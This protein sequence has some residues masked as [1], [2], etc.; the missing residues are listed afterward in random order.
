[1]YVARGRDHRSG[2]A[3][4]VEGSTAVGTRVVPALS[5]IALTASLAACGDTATT[6]DS[7]ERSTSS[8]TPPGTVGDA[9]AAS[10]EVLAAAVLHRVD[11]Y[12]GGFYTTLFIID[13]VG[14]YTADAGYIT[15]WVDGR[16]LSALE[17]TAIETALGPRAVT[18]ISHWRDVRGEPPSDVLPARQAIILLAEP[19]IDESRAEV[20]T[21]LSCGSTCSYGATSMLERSSGGE[22]LVTGET[23]VFVS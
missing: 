8:A 11:T 18:W 2:C 3:G 19:S 17:R 4:I 5:L 12:A 1:M 15:D 22:W 10:P 9:D 13:R 6:G 21:E 16:P 7:A 20:A 23:N 14:R